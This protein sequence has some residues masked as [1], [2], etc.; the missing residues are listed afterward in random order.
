MTNTT[1]E[2]VVAGASAWWWG[3][4]SLSLLEGVG[5]ALI[6]L[7]ALTEAIDVSPAPK[8]TDE[9]NKEGSTA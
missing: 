8:R 1:R 9:P 5:G 4:E 3:G 2:L 6:A 7:A